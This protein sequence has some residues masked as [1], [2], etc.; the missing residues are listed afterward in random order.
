[1]Q[2]KRSREVELHEMNR[3]DDDFLYEL[4]TP[5]N[6]D[7]TIQIIYICLPF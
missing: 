4:F 2:N 3:K 1:M 7:H 5:D 6:I